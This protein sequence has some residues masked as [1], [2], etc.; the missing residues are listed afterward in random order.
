MKIE[1]L[2]KNIFGYLIVCADGPFCERLINICMNRKM[3]IRDIHRCGQNR[4]TFSIDIPSYFKIRTPAKR[5]KS[6]VRIIKRCGLPFILQKYK[7]RRFIII[8]VLLL[9]TA[10]WYSSTHIMGITVVGNHHLSEAEIISALSECGLNLGVKTSDID[11]DL[12]RNKMML[13]LPE[14]GWIGFNA[15][16]SRIYVEIVERLEKEKG[17]DKNAPVQN[18]IASKD[19]EIEKI[20]VREGQ[21]MVKIGSGVR[22]GDVL[23]S[24]ILNSVGTGIRFVSSRGEIIA[25]TRYTKKR[26]YPIN[27]SETVETGRKT[28]RY[29]LSVL[30][31]KVPL[32]FNGEPPYT[33]FKH[34]HETQE[35]RTP[36]DFIPSLFISRDTYAENATHEK[37][38]TFKETAEFGISEL[39]AELKSELPEGAEII[40]E[41]SSHTLTEKNEVEV[42]VEIICRENIAVP[43]VIE[44]GGV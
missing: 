30:N 36:L 32:F 31:I 12:L 15:N 29:T 26:A 16:G 21:T 24:G 37:T 40:N 4:V 9:A 5:T 1:D 17:I 28:S 41:N 19:G 44:I 39:T 33:S 3:D 27:Y 11:N 6:H 43:S 23:V 34:E 25:K 13:K 2:L 18:L 20:E 22:K 38:R 7:K 42:T 14:L 10:L 35:Y 8:I